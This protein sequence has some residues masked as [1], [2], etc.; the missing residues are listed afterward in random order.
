MGADIGAGLAGYDIE[1]WKLKTK[2]QQ[3]LRGEKTYVLDVAKQ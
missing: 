3:K 2:M 1:K